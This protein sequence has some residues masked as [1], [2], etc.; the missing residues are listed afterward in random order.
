LLLNSLTCWLKPVPA[1]TGYI[2]ASQ[3][4]FKLIFVKLMEGHFFRDQTATL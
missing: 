2:A 1:E 4:S 3:Q